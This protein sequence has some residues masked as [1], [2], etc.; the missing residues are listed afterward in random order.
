MSR[1]NIVV[2]FI[3]T[4]LIVAT[5][6]NE[7]R[8]AW[9]IEPVELPGQVGWSLFLDS[10]PTGTVQAAFY[11]SSPSGSLRYTRRGPAGWQQAAVIN[12]GDAFAT[13][14]TGNRFFVSTPG[15]GPNYYP[16]YQILL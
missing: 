1:H 15:P 9:Q 7:S 14:N 10:D 3:A 16:Q 6:A 11:T 12:S 8:A 13:D 5:L 4:W 2:P